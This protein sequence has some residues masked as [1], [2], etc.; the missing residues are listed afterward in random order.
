VAGS[1]VD[2]VVH[3]RRLAYLPRPRPATGDSRVRMFGEAGA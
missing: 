3:A 2:A 1:G